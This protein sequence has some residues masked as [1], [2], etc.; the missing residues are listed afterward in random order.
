MIKH[1]KFV[2]VLWKLVL[3]GSGHTTESHLTLYS[4]MLTYR[5][6]RVWNY[7]GGGGF[8]LDFENDIVEL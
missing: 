8:S 3:A 1:K 5:W 7:M 6:G 2:L 4:S